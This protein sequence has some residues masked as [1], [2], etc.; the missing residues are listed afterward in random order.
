MSSAEETPIKQDAAAAE[1]PSE[2][3]EQSQVDGSGPEGNGSELTDTKFNVEV[4]L[5]DLQADPNNPLFSV[6]SF[7]DLQLSEALLKGIRNMN[8]RKPSKV[9][10]KALPLLLLNP[11][12]NMIAQSQSGTGKTAAFSLNI[13]SRIDLANPEPQALALAPSREL[14][15]QILGVIT[16]MGQFMDGLKTMA[17][18]PDP[19]RR[20]QQF[21]AQVLVGTPGTVQDMLRR[22][23][24]NSKYIKILV[25]DE[26]DNMLDQQG[27]G[28]Q[29]TRVKALL[30][31]D[32]QTVLFSATFPPNVIAYAKRFAPNANTLTLAHEELTIEGIK[33]LYI[34]IDK[35]NDKYAT[36]LKFYGLM[37]Q[38]SSIIFVRTRKTA[39]ELEQRMVAEGHKVAQLSGALEGPERDR[40][41]D[42]FRSGEA[43]VL[44][45]TNVLARGID[46]QSVT[47]VIN[48]D[49]PTMA[50]GIDADPET[51]LHRIGRTGRFGRVGVALTFV[52]DKASWQ[53]LHAIASY[54]RTDLHPIDTSDW[55][56]VEDMIQTVIKSSRAG[57]TTEEMTEMITKGS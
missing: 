55:D 26:A 19:S 37:T 20:G 4:K 40:I 47:M 1:T 32:I 57:K 14:A 54:F 8:F 24:I 13:L 56:A 15:R 25:L 45:T 11:P 2:S 34:D 17:A 3:V 5:A 33:Q 16:H 53:Q 49:V 35:D 6:K 22:R 52:H 51:Y 48:Y 29:C 36:L 50:N 27:L 28:D 43:K 38:A 30:P 42:Q 7:E 18:I 12:T 46:V 9:Q 31:K 44:I 23:L 10:E 21:N 39:E 41:I